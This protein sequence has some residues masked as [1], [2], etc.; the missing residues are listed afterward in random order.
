M[1]IRHRFIFLGIIILS[2]GCL[3]ERSKENGLT[4]YRFLPQNASTHILIKNP[5]TQLV[6]GS[7]SEFKE[8]IEERL[9]KED[10]KIF[11]YIL[12]S[13]L[14]DKTRELWLSE[15]VGK[16]GEKKWF[17]SFY[18]HHSEKSDTVQKEKTKPDFFIRQ[19]NDK[20]Q[21]SRSETFFDQNTAKS[22]QR[23]NDFIE[24]YRLLKPDK[25]IVLFINQ[26]HNPSMVSRFFSKTRKVNNVWTMIDWEKT[27]GDLYFSGISKVKQKDDQTK[28]HSLTSALGF[29][30]SDVHA[31]E[32]FSQIPYSFVISN[33]SDSIS[34]EKT[35]FSG[36]FLNLYQSDSKLY[37]ILIITPQDRT[38]ARLR[39]NSERVNSNDQY[40]IWRVENPKAVLSRLPS[41]WKSVFFAKKENLII[42]S[43]R[44]QT[45]YSTLNSIKKK[46]AIINDHE[47]KDFF[48]EFPDS[49]DSFFFVRNE[50]IVSIVDMFLNPE[51]TGKGKKNNFIGVQLSK[52]ANFELI[53]GLVKES[54]ANKKNTSLLWT[55]KIDQ[56]PKSNPF[57]I[58]NHRSGNW[59]MVI[60]DNKN[61]LQLIDH[62]GKDQWSKPVDGEIL[63]DIH[64]MDMFGNRKLQM[65][66]NT[67]KK[68]YVLDIFGNSV[69][70]FPIDLKK[71]ASAGLGL[72]DYD[73]KRK[74]RLAIPSGKSIQ[75]FDQRGKKVNGFAFSE[76]A[77]LIKTTPQH[78]RIRSKDYIVFHD[79]LGNPY[80]LHRTGKIRVSPKPSLKLSNNPIFEDT[81]LSPGWLALSQEGALVHIGTN[82]SAY[83][84]QKND[85]KKAQRF[86]VSDGDRFIFY[87]GIIE[88]SGNKNFTTPR[89]YKNSIV[90]FSKVNH[91]S[92]WSVVLDTLLNETMILNSQGIQMK[93]FPVEGSA[94]ATIGSYG[95]KKPYI[96][97]ISQKNGT[98][99]AYSIARK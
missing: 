5:L 51:K 20:I 59:N 92:V 86:F 99:Q 68:L 25:E 69:S 72:F 29:V 28:K 76:A 11:Q 97:I 81:R 22:N 40:S 63:G 53:Q 67:K 32:I 12:D 54:S 70:P 16:T 49:F 2:F 83:K 14:T 88:R 39:D 47:L 61:T 71:Q 27:R 3:P 6:N 57:L 82:G 15:A 10:Q 60:Q 75:M 93:G 1:N 21:I 55:S 80:F 23:E 7:L 52:E 64:Q 46:T 58:K 43:N 98:I 95:K 56:E 9:P 85:L 84:K 79:N 17:F 90:R 91:S 50:P 35:P 19:D 48:S 94:G 65:V 87:N 96:A 42:L 74:Y 4:L 38:V 45:I 77:G 31:F 62:K 37:A 30:P 18:K 78:F 8:K 13:Q 36:T 26:K 66:F 33:Q 24:L 41:N 44:R 89:N 73:R 34:K